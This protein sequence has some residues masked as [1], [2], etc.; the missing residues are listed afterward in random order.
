[1]V[2]SD[3]FNHIARFVAFTGAFTGTFTGTFVVLFLIALYIFRCLSFSFDR[4]AG[5]FTGTFTGTFTLSVTVSVSVSYFL[6]IYFIDFLC[7]LNVTIIKPLS[8]FHI[9]SSTP[10]LSHASIIRLAPEP[11]LSR[12]VDLYRAS[13]IFRLYGYDS[14]G[15]FIFSGVI[16][17]GNT[18]G[19]AISMRSSY[20]AILV[21][22]STL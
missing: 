18:P 17:G 7:R 13:A 4:L 3:T 2:F 11:Q 5:I 22:L 21:V 9:G 12:N 16:C 8:H 14:C 20:M 1:M 19:L 15:F 10:C 6:Y